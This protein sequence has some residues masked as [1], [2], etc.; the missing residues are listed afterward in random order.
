[1]TGALRTFLPFATE[2][3]DATHLMSSTAMK[4]FPDPVS[5]VAITLLRH[6]LLKICTDNNPSIKASWE[7][8]NKY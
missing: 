3:C 1:M 4:V 2:G 7:S 5:N 8:L 6:A